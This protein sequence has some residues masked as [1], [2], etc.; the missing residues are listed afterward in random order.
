[1]NWAALMVWFFCQRSFQDPNVSSILEWN[2]K[3]SATLLL[4]NLFLSYGA[5]DKE[6]ITINLMC[7]I[8]WAMWQPDTWWNIILDVFVMISRDESNI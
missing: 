2:S 6:T 4:L 7:Q 3:D 5:E 1:M 8:Y